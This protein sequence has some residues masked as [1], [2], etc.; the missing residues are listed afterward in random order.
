[1]ETVVDWVF[2]QNG[3]F[4]GY[5]DTPASR[6]LNYFTR[7]FVHQFRNDELSDLVWALAGIEALIVEGGRSSVGQLREKLCALFAETIDQNWLS[8]MVNSSYDFAHEWC[9]EID[10]YVHLS[11]Q[12]K[13][14]ARNDRRRK[15][16][17]VCSQSEFSFCFSDL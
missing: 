10:K 2:A 7:L 4:H 1:L 12:M 15:T 16:R 8:K 13:M 9:M 5:S 14:T 6:A 11:E 17:A 3:I